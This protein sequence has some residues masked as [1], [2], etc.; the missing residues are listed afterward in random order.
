MLQKKDGGTCRQGDRNYQNEMERKKTTKGRASVNYV[1]QPNT[2]IFLVL[3]KMGEQ[4]KILGEIMAEFNEKHKPRI[5]EAEWTP[6]RRNMKKT[7]SKYIKNKLWNLAFYLLVSCLIFFGRFFY[8][9]T[10]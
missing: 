9:Q 3:E 5:Q 7:R 4:N 2:C 6:G 8:F 1:T 10:F